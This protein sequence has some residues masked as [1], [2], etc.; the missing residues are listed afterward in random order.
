MTN[1]RE[2]LIR[3]DEDDVTVPLLLSCKQLRDAACLADE[4]LSGEM[5]PTAPLWHI[6]RKRVINAL[7]EAVR[8]SEG[9]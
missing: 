6:E 4:F 8:A 1:E 7:R 2:F 3:T 9:E 5:T